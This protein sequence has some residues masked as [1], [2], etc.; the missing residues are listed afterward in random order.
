[1]RYAPFALALSLFAAACGGAASTTN[2]TAPGTASTVTAV[3]VGTASSSSVA[4]A[5][6]QLLANARF[7]DGTMRDVTSEARWESSDASLA[8]ISA[9]G[10]VTVVGTGDVELRAT[11]QNI[12]GSMH[13]LVGLQPRTTA[14]LIG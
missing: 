13:A 5:T 9:T 12:T 6:F 8:R 14:T 1:M 4:N 10:T 2:P 3:T 11:Y 7:G